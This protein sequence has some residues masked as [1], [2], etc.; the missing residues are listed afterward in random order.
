MNAQID[1]GADGII[2]DY[3]TLLR[4]VMADRGMALPQA[5]KR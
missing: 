2:T 5:Y 4:Q 1:A 3:P